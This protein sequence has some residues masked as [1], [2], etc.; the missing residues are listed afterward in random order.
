LNEADEE[1]DCKNCEQEFLQYQKQREKRED[2]KIVAAVAAAAVAGAATANV[3]NVATASTAN[4]NNNNST[5]DDLEAAGASAESFNGRTNV[6]TDGQKP[7]L[8]RS[9]S[10]A[11]DT[12]TETGSAYKTDSNMNE[13]QAK[14]RSKLGKI[15]AGI[16]ILIEIILLITG[17]TDLHYQILVYIPIVLGVFCEVQGRE[18]IVIWQGLRGLRLKDKKFNENYQRGWGA[19]LDGTHEKVD[20]CD[21]YEGQGE[22]VRSHAVFA[23]FRVAIYSIFIM[24]F[25]FVL[26][27]MVISNGDITKIGDVAKSMFPLFFGHQN[28]QKG[29]PTLIVPCVFLI[30]GLFACIMAHSQHSKGV[31]KV[32]LWKDM[33]LVNVKRIFVEQQGK[34]NGCIVDET[35]STTKHQQVQIHTKNFYKQD[36]NMNFDGSLKTGAAPLVGIDNGPF[37]KLNI[38]EI[39]QGTIGAVI[40]HVARPG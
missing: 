6:D 21:D 4:N 8:N 10:M 16:A 17:T 12:T 2:A 14:T 9:D 1:E 22:N 18:R 36:L 31:V 19:Q 37:G 34:L 35:E 30:I 24:A 40:F 39:L 11:T 27:A 32:V 26:T 20:V 23:L 25:F 15:L 38:E 3:A 7:T 13:K 28:I 5:H 29:W 33:K